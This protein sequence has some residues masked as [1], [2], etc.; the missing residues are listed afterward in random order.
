MYP[1]KLIVEMV[2]GDRSATERCFGYND[3]IDAMT[4]EIMA[5][6]EVEVLA[7]IIISNL[8]PAEAIQKHIRQGLEGKV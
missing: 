3:A 5:R 8:H 4:A 2:V 1:E 6:T 7:E